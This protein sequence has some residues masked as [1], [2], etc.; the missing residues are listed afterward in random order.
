M[1]KHRHDINRFVETAG[2]WVIV[3]I[4]AVHGSTPR[5]EGAWMLVGQDTIFR[6]IGGGELERMAIEQARELLGSGDVETLELQIPLGPHIGQCCGGTVNLRI[7]LLDEL[8]LQVCVELVEEELARLP[9]VLIFG[10]GHVG[11]ALAESLSLM[12]VH[13]VLIDTREGELA[14]SP[15]GV[16][17]CLTAM[18]EM[19]VRD[20]RPGSAF[21]VLTHDHSLD[22]LITQ[23]ALA[24]TDAAYVGMIGSKTKRATFRNWLRRE[25]GSETGI[26]GLVCPIGD[27]TVNDKR[28]EVIAALASAEIMAHLHR[29]ASVA[30]K[31]GQQLK[32]QRISGGY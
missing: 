10:A 19:Q 20:A 1:Y 11:Y 25:N 14:A 18:P 6:T 17:T 7:S 12:P 4:D 5:E 32:L 24:R 2:K 27:P 21:V 31:S 9:R 22:F 23:A 15:K 16:E 13:P 30:V 29:Y 26:E 8:G 28:P 3:E